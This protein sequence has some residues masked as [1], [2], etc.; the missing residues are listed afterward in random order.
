M[1]GFVIRLINEVDV[2]ANG[3]KVLLVLPFSG[4]GVGGGLAVVNQEFARGFM[5]AGD[6]VIVLAMEVPEAFAP[7]PAD[8][9]G[10]KI[11]LIKNS[12]T[13]QV[14]NPGG[15]D[16]ERQL[17]YDEMRKAVE[18]PAITSAEQ[19]GLPKGWVPD[20]IIGHSRFSGP[21]SIILQN[22]FFTGAGTKTTYVLHSDPIGTSAVEGMESLGIVKSIQEMY[23]MNR[24]DQVAANG[25][26][27]RDVAFRLAFTGALWLGKSAPPPV[28]EFIPGHTLA[29]PVRTTKP[30]KSPSPL[31]IAILGRLE[32]SLKGFD[33]LL[34]AVRYA[35]FLPDCPHIEVKALGFSMPEGMEVEEYPAHIEEMQAAI[36]KLLSEQGYRKTGSA[37]GVDQ[38]EGPAPTNAQVKV[39]VLAST[40]EKSKVVEVLRSADLL[41]MPSH[42][43]GMGVVAS[44]AF[45]NGVPPVVNEDSGISR[46][47]QERFSEFSKNLVVPDMNRAGV[48]PQLYAE[49]IVKLYRNYQT[50]WDQTRQIREYLGDFKW[51]D[52]AAFIHNAHAHGTGGALLQQEPKGTVKVLP[53]SG[54]MKDLGEELAYELAHILADPS[55]GKLFAE[56][57]KVAQAQP[58]MKIDAIDPLKKVLDDRSSTTERRAEIDKVVGTLQEVIASRLVERVHEQFK[59]DV[60][61]LVEQEKS[62]LA[63]RKSL[64]EQVS[65]IAT[66]VDWQNM[67]ASIDTA[68]REAVQE[69]LKTEPSLFYGPSSSALEIVV[70]SGLFDRVAGILGSETLAGIAGSSVKADQDLATLADKLDSERLDAATADIL[71]KA[72]STRITPYVEATATQ[73]ILEE[74]AHNVAGRKKELL[75]TIAEA[76]SAGSTVSTELEAKK[77]ELAKVEEQVKESPTDANTALR[78][79]LKDE[80]ERLKDADPVNRESLDREEKKVK[81]ELADTKK[82]REKAE[83]VLKK[84][85][86]A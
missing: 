62:V 83:G 40:K 71:W 39:E 80:V 21:A 81:E 35:S 67:K 43:E 59:I 70:K 31:K 6:D 3:K 20:E 37:G 42:Q 29:D 85:V 41:V 38:W 10:A 45:E 54:I 82:E 16:A 24:A 65:G 27:L 72:W 51:A 47:L 53:S 84:G 66:R 15:S 23:W 57:D 1:F 49:A 13:S 7:K 4:R 8:H 19:L 76:S 5:E 33:D 79:R 73:T 14:K 32:A 12:R 60:A 55:N 11:V 74:F 68:V 25:P 2:M 48:R 69:I 26:H 58:D 17:L 52:T 36:N 30:E 28:I 75:Q 77:Y 64:T 56:L 46:F 44:E 50:V 61:K 34:R 9:G 18:D 63:F 78:D 22:R 86:G